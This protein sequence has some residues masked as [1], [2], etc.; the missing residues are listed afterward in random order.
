[1]GEDEGGPGHVEE[2]QVEGGGP[3]GE[4]GGEEVGCDGEGEEDVHGE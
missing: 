1:M 4:G 2:E 3:G